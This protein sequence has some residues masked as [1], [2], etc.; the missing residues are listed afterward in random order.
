MDKYIFSEEVSPIKLGLL[1]GDKVIVT[2]MITEYVIKTAKTRQRKFFG[3]FL[4]ESKYFFTIKG[5]NYSESYMKKDLK[6]K[7][8]TITKIK[9]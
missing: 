1:P 8:V 4:S 3:E 5:D 6:L 7:R 9:G 2:C